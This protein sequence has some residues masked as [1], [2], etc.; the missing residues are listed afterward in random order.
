MLLRMMNHFYT[1]EKKCVCMHFKVFLYRLQ[2]DLRDTFICSFVHNFNHNPSE[3]DFSRY[4][5]A[6]P[7]AQ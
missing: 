6:Y 2:T 1:V 4:M 3:F 7:K 5:S